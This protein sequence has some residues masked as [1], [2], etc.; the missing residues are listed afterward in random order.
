MQG[1]FKDFCFIFS[2]VYMSMSLCGYVC[3]YSV[4]GGH[5][6]LQTIV[7]YLSWVL[8]TELGFFVRAANIL[9]LLSHFLHPQISLLFQV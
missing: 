5:K 6:R 2:C 8:W 9:N 4:Q 7:N 3:E 1:R